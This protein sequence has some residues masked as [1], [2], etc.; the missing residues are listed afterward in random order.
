MDRLLD[1]QLAHGLRSGQAEAWGAL[2]EAYA[3]P[4]WQSV[5]RWMGPGSDD[6][7]DVVQE[8][9]LAAA[10]SARGYDPQRG[11]IRLWLLGIA[12]RHVAMHYRRE[13]RQDQVRVAAQRL[14]PGH[15]AVVRWLENREP[16]PPDALHLAETAL[17]VRAALARL[18]TEYGTLLSDRYLDGMDVEELAEVHRCTESALRS[19]LARAR[20]AFREAF[21][22]VES[23]GP[24]VRAKGAI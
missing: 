8:T 10:R 18:S 22:H 24:V 21:A 12:R 17:M 2:Y 23:G 6:V 7:A 13:G 20:R 15:Q 5:A 3:R 9:F 19:K 16:N 14:G 11:S 1:E 4:V